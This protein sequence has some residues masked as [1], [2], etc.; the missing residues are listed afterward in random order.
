MSGS[1]YFSVT[2]DATG[3]ALWK[4]D[5]TEGGTL[6][7]CPLPVVS[8]LWTDVADLLYLKSTTATALSGRH[9]RATVPRQ[10]R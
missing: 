8:T 3:S 9:G 6:V 1:L 10:E 4:S 2:E 7:S 5:G